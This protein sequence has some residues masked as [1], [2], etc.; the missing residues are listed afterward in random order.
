MCKIAK[1]KYLEC[2]FDL[3]AKDDDEPVEASEEED[4]DDEPVR[5]NVV[6]R[7]NLPIGLKFLEIEFTNAGNIFLTSSV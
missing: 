4:D 1:Q 2:V 3:C 5:H 7:F 6:A